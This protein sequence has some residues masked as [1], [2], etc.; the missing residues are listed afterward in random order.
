MTSLELTL[1]A[2]GLAYLILDRHVEQR[3]AALA[4]L[5]Q[6]SYRCARCTREV[7]NAATVRPIRMSGLCRRHYVERFG[8]LQPAPEMSTYRQRRAAI[9]VIDSL[10]FT[11]IGK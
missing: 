6:G 10:R 11:T 4:A 9:N 8:R 2:L 1:I 7:Y 5:P 3:Q